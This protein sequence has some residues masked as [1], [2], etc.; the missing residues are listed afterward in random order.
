MLEIQVRS[1]S[2]YA[3]NILLHYCS[4]LR[5]YP[6]EHQI[7]I[8]LHRPVVSKD[9][10]SFLRPDNFAGRDVPA[11][12]TRET[13]S[14]GFGQVGLASSQLLFRLLQIVNIGNQDIPADNTT[15]RVAECE[16]THVEPAIHAIGPADPVLNVVG[17]P[18]LDRATPPV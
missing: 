15:L 2:C 3:I 12:T 8:G 14:L 5:M 13:Q 4:F 6:I 11:E 10:I 18:G 1:V 7:Q 16:A 9:A 17:L